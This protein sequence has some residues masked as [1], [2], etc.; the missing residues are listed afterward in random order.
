M[1]ITVVSQASTW[2]LRRLVTRYSCGANLGIATGHCCTNAPLSLY[3]AQ[4]IPFSRYV[5]YAYV[6]TCI[7]ER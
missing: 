6:G 4:Q 3:I 2:P 7:L 5:Y 1:K